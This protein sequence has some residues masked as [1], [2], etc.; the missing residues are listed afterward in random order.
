MISTNSVHDSLK[1]KKRNNNQE[2]HLLT[3]TRKAKPTIEINI[4]S[5]SKRKATLELEEFLLGDAG[6]EGPMLNIRKNFSGSEGSPSLALRKTHDKPTS[7]SQQSSPSQG[8][9]E[10][11]MSRGES[12]SRSGDTSSLGGSPSRSRTCYSEGE[13]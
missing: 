4:D 9:S 12:P 1:P 7:L 10:G 2:I 3:C 11:R 8:R 13:W 5:A 6:E